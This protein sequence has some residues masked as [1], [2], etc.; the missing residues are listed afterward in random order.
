MRAPQSLQPAS[1][2]LFESNETL[3][4]C[5][6]PSHRHRRLWSCTPG[7]DQSVPCRQYGDAS[8]FPGLAALASSSEGIAAI[9]AAKRRQLQS[10]LAICVGD[11]F[12]IPRYAETEHLPRGCTC[13]F[14]LALL[15]HLT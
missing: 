4:G 13:D 10:P 5:I 1:C 12:D 15:V 8:W 9:Y 14:A 6:I 11:A 7:F 2:R 3:V